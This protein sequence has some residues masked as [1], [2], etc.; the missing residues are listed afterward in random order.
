MPRRIAETTLNASTIDILNVIRANASAEYQQYVPEVTK[1]TDIPKVGEAIFG[2]GGLANQFLFAL[3]N[4]IAAVRIKSA[5]FNNR[6][7]VFNKGYLEFGETVEEVFVNLAKAREFSAEK[8]EKRELKRT[9]PDVRTALHVMNYR[10]QYPI[11]IQDMDLRQAFTSLDGVTDMIARIVQSVYTAADYDEY[12]L[13]KYVLVKSISHGKTFNIGVDTTNIKNAAVAFRGTS[14]RLEFISTQYNNSGV[15]TSTIRDDQYIFM[16]AD[17]NAQYDTEILAAA[18]H[19]DKADFMGHLVLV[20]DWTAF[21]NERFAVIR[22]G[23]DMIDEV[24]DGELA[25]MKDVIAVIADKE[26][27]QFYDNLSQMS[28]KYVASGL[29]W[30]YFYN[31]WK[32]VSVSPFS[33]VVSF[34]K[35]S[36]DI[37]LPDSVTVKIADKATSN[38][39]TVF[40]LVVDDTEASFKPSEVNFVQT[41]ALT[42]SGVGVTK[43]GALL[44]PA[45]AT[46][47]SGTLCVEI[48]GT[49]YLAADTISAAAAVGTAF[50]LN[51]Q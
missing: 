7:R 15:H 5:L 27:F 35:D 21:D 6:F 3:M 8:A 41:Q 33:N 39:A 20:D 14:N 18:F 44:I 29:Y 23:S 2:H 43:Y 17:F 24:T 51:K 1:A 49:Q 28:E 16:D 50:T 12:L 22:E 40:S 34:V 4:R 19:M 26:F 30:N 13:Y 32:T 37:A 25:L 45:S 47:F 42:Q 36:A 38:E 9:L 46:E 11:T 10:V 31:V 48:R